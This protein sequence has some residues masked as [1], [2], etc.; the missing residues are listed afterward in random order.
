MAR[1]H[2]QIHALVESMRLANHDRDLRQKNVRDVRSGE[3]D[4][5]VP[6]SMPDAWPKPIVANVIDTT[7]RDIAEVMGVMPAINCTNG[8]MTSQRAKKFSGKRTKIASHYITVSRLEAGK[9]VEFC[10]QYSTFGMAVYSVEPDFE[11]KTPVIR[12]ESPIGCYPEMDIFGNLR[13]FTKVWAEKAVDLLSKYPQLSRA[14]RPGVTPYGQDPNA[15][16]DQMIKIAKYQDKDTIY[17]YLPDR[18]N[19]MV[20]EM[21]NPMGRV[22]VSVAI[23]PS[24]D[25]KVRGAFDEAI[26]VYL[27]KARMALLGLEATEKSVRSTLFVPR[28]I[29]T[30]EFGGDAIARTDNPEKARYLAPDFPQFANQ[31]SQMLAQELM[32][33][34]RSPGVRN[35]NVDASIITGKGVQALMGGF[36]TVITTGQA[37]IGQALERAIMMAFDMDE[38]L[39]PNEKKMIRG[40]VQ[41]SPFEENYIPSKDIDGN[42]MVDVTYGFAAGQDPARAIVALL[43]LRGDKLVSRD[44]VQRQLPMQ[45]DVV[46]MQQQVDNEDFEDA[47]KAGTQMMM[48]QIGSLAIQGQDPTELL[49]KLAQV[50]KSRENGESVHDAVLGA[51]KPKQAPGGPGG[52]QEAQQGPPGPGGP[53]GPPQAP[54]GAPQG[55][56]G[57]GMDMMQLLASLKTGAGG[58]STPSMIARTRRQV[59]IG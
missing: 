44:F 42:H 12:V 14:I 53:G 9:Q 1:S 34:T 20:E 47:L 11:N 23:R 30:F 50:I 43:Q 10:D 37:V 4:T 29:T 46:Q 40:V 2:D 18:G 36:N 25:G 54:G 59:P 45:I 22:M 15:W 3:I 57:G 6:Q 17:M 21:P 13:S 41:G 38:K 19:T 56:G 32:I 16:R 33:A 49:V 35:G 7:A 5:V 48:Q 58:Q 39:W 26:W 51:F 24:Y 8:I 31:E 52:P 55:P 28:D 27:A